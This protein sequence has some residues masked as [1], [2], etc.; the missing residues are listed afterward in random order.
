MS[1]AATSTSRVPS[2][3]TR[4]NMKVKTIVR[5]RPTLKLEQPDAGINIDGNSIA[6]VNPRDP[7]AWFRF[8]FHSVHGPKAGQEDIYRNDVQDLIAHVWKGLGNAILEQTVTVFAYG[9]TSSGKTHTMQGNSTD[10]GIIPRVVEALFEMRTAADEIHMTYMEIYRDEVYDLLVGGV[11]GPKLP[12]REDR[13]GKVVVANLTEMPLR[14]PAEFDNAFAKAI[15]SRS[16]GATNLNHA[17]SRSHAILSLNITRTEGDTSLTGSINLVDLAGSENNKLTGNDPAR[18]LESAAINK[19]LATLG[20]VVHAL[21]QGASRIPYRDSKLT[22]ILQ[23]ALGGSSIGLLICNLA[24]GAKFRTDTLNTLNFAA[25]T[26]EIE[27]RPTV[28]ERDNR[29]VP[30]PHFAAVQPA[31]APPPSRSVM[32]LPRRL[33][34]SIATPMVMPAPVV[35]SSSRS[36]SRQSLLPVPGPSRGPRP[37]VAVDETILRAQV[38]RKVREEMEKD[39]ERERQRLV[40]ELQEKAQN[41]RQQEL[42]RALDAERLLT[43]ELRKQREMEIQEERERQR[44]EQEEAWQKK[45]AEMEAKIERVVE[46]QVAKRLAEIRA[47]EQLQLQ[48]LTAP[49]NSTDFDDRTSVEHILSGATPLL[50]S[51]TRTSPATEAD[52]KMRLEALERKTQMREAEEQIA[53]KLSPNGKKSAAKAH[54][55]YARE[56]EAKGDLETALEFFRRAQVYIPQNEKLKVRIDAMELAIEKEKSGALPVTMPIPKRP[57]GRSSAPKSQP[58]PAPLEVVY[59]DD[60]CE[61]EEALR[62]D[63]EQLDLALSQMRPS[64]RTRSKLKRARG[65]TAPLEEIALPL[66]ETATDVDDAA[67]VIDSEQPAK[68]KKRAIGKGKGK[69]GKVQTEWDVDSDEEEG[70]NE[71]GALGLGFAAKIRRRITRKARISKV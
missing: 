71:A 45:Q 59:E 35:S 70:E 49:N 66:P 38:E 9:V 23:D 36:R 57:S 17:S 41:E 12:V 37:S 3:G 25:R 60:E 8:N 19:S 11:N 32:P 13:D 20:Q 34:V 64:S 27:N 21:N 67:M 51:Q 61:T 16:T 39:G 31:R 4:S 26:R 7:T 28:N 10:P 22:R 29:P 55:A 50:E 44:K 58:P 65:G 53:P 24:P 69:K 43:E 54:V 48:Q 56:R 15:K 46:E 63:D 33:S 42:Q 14:S 30:K 5:L 62:D 52:L 47:Q 18:M 68:K 1:S 2:N 40:R 6:V